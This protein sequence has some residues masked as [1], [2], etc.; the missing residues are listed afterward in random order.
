MPCRREIPQQGR[1]ERVDPR[2]RREMSKGFG[3]GLTRAFELTL[4]PMIVGGVGFA[5]DRW[6]GLTPV[7]TIVF[8]FW[9]LIATTY[10]A[11]VRY[12][13]D[14]TVEE[15]IRAES[16]TAHPVPSSDRARRYAENVAA[17]QALDV[18]PADG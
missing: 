9:G 10:L 4:T 14:M 13:H 18:R 16:R 5:L 11:W 7:L 15:G 3:D 2:E 6:L 12:D 17:A 8:A 1:P